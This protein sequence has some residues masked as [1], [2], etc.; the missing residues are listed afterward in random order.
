MRYRSRFYAVT[1]P[2]P[3]DA[4]GVLQ[5]GTTATGQ[6]TV[7]NFPFLMKRIGHAIIGPNGVVN[8]GITVH[9]DVSQDG[10]YNIKFRTDDR[11]YMNEPVSALGAFG[12]GQFSQIVDLPAPIEIEPKVTIAVDVTTT[13]TRQQG[14]SVQVIF[15]GVEP[16]EAAPVGS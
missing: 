8:A 11:N 5:A 7:Q 13:I 15:E 14:I 3:A 6:V 9:A 4:G 2:L 16:Y 1:V 10:Q 12:G